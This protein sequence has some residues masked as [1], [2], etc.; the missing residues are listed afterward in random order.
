M[1]AKPSKAGRG[2]KHTH[3]DMEGAAA[4]CLGTSTRSPVT[5][6]PCKPAQALGPVTWAR[7]RLWDSTVV[8]CG[9][10][11][12]GHECGLGTAIPPGAPSWTHSPEPSPH[13]APW[14]AGLGGGG[15]VPGGPDCDSAG[16]GAREWWSVACQVK[17]G[18]SELK[19][20][21]YFNRSGCSEGD[22]R[23]GR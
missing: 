22:E 1:L 5:G 2:K 20:H 19:I 9:L 18:A 11:R 16:G 15:R 6:P 13:A 7:S 14:W 23:E 3:R 10:S 12:K 4:T 21:I 8:S 17:L